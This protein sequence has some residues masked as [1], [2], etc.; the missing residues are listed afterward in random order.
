M[1]QGTQE[2]LVPLVVVGEFVVVCLVIWIFARR[3]EQ[4]ARLRAELQLKLLE[5]FSNVRE[6]E[7]FLRTDIGRQL[8]ASSAR[9]SSPLT[10]VAV[11][12]QIGLVIC[13]LALGIMAAGVLQS[14]KGLFVMGVIVLTFGAGLVAAAILGRRLVR[15]WGLGSAETA[16]V[17]QPRTS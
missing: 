3:R 5:R 2:L 15:D 1:S 16:P 13:V 12:A 17:S 7:E 10:R 6:L 14:V 4:A 11:T 9:A 8:M